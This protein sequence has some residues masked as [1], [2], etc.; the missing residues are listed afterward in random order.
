MKSVAVFEAMNTGQPVTKKDLDAA[1]KTLEKML[2][3]AV[4]KGPPGYASR[5]QDSIERA[6]KYKKLRGVK[7]RTFAEI[8]RDIEIAQEM[9]N[10]YRISRKYE[11]AARWERNRDEYGKEYSD[12]LLGKA[13]IPKVEEA[14]DHAARTYIPEGF[15]MC[16]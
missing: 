7:Q 9:V 11:Q 8:Q 2:T 15:Q 1:I 10:E 16:L 3:E 12:A 5:I 14:D 13:Y 6:R 4:D